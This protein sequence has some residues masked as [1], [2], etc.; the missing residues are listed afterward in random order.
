ML[1]SGGYFIIKNNLFHVVSKQVCSNIM[2]LRLRR[3]KFVLV[4]HVVNERNVNKIFLS[5]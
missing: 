2:D 1:K 4:H 3:I 5:K